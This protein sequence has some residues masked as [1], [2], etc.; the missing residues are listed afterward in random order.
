MASSSKTINPLRKF[1]T[2]NQPATLDT[3]AK[4]LSSSDVR[5]VVVLA[6]AGISTS[7]GIPDF[8]SPET[9]LYANLAKYNLPYAE[10]IFDITYFHQHPQPFFTLS[11]EL[12]PGNFSPTLTHHFFRLLNEKKKLR[13]VFTQNIDTL[14][15]LAG[16]DS[17]RIVE[18]HGSFATSRCTR[19]G[20]SV[21]ADWIKEKC[22]K[23]EVAYH[24][25]DEKCKKRGEGKGGLVKPDIVC[26]LL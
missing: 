23:G 10:A 4:L 19:C 21:D 15:R 16:L 26:E 7:A 1:V 22:A 2:G 13:R 20:K 9:G 18:A 25:D 8:R 17:D 24:E 5:N 3:V 14:E 6:G 12:Y 11:R